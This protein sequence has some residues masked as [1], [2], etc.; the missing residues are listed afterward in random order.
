MLYLASLFEIFVPRLCAACDRRLHPWEQSLCLECLGEMP[1]TKFH[2][3]TYH[4]L[5]QMFWGRVPLEQV[6]AWFYFIKDS[7]YQLMMHRFKYQNEPRIGY[8]LGK[9]YGYQLHD[10]KHFIRPDL[11]VPVPLHPKK[12]RKRGYNQSAW[13]ARGLAEALEIPMQPDLLIRTGFTDTQTHKSRFDR[14]LNVTGKFTVSRPDQIVRKHILLADDVITT[15][16]TIEACA[17]T[18]LKYEGVK[19]SA[20]ALAWAKRQF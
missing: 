16:A 13:L 14:Y 20:A 11:I 18:L 5:E 1:L 9:L 4:P 2:K 15:G 7:R 8:D 12:E 17:E 3:E 19:V 10:S 6:V